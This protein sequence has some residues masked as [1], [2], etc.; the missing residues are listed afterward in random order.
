MAGMPNVL[1]AKG[2]V[3]GSYCALLLAGTILHGALHGSLAE[4][5]VGVCELDEMDRFSRKFAFGKRDLVEFLEDVSS[6]Y[7]SSTPERQ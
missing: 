5:L 3:K 2:F 4:A 1:P 7:I 6:F